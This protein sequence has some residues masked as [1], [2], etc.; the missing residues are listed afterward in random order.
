MM[1][2]MSLALLLEPIASVSLGPYE[3]HNLLI[4]DDTSSCALETHRSIHF[5][6]P[7]KAACR[8]SSYCVQCQCQWRLMYPAA[9][10]AVRG[11]ECGQWNN[12]GVSKTR[13]DQDR[14]SIVLAHGLLTHPLS[15]L[16][17]SLD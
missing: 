9:A 8:E 13:S 1:T 14:E 4:G 2:C 6:A 15:V 10:N 16:E 5:P 3:V 11:S 12:W 17:K 7:A